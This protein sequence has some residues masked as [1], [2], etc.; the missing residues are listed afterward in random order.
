MRRL[1][2]RLLYTIAII[3]WLLVMSFPIIA[4]VLATQQQIQIGDDSR[5]HVRL[6]LLQEENAQ[7]VGIEWAR[8]L[9]ENRSCSKTS[10]NYLLWEGEAKPASYCQCFD[11]LTSTLLPDALSAC[12]NES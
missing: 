9:R 11:T 8:P 1:P 6:F 2:R 5:R 10:V 7:G 3:I 12:N 4:M